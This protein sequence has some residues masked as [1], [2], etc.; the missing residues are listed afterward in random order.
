MKRKIPYK[1]RYFSTDWSSVDLGS[2]SV[3]HAQAH[4]VN[5]YCFCCLPVN[6]LNLLTFHSHRLS[7]PQEEVA[8]TILVTTWYTSFGI[9][10][11]PKPPLIL[12]KF[13]HKGAS[14]TFEVLGTDSVRGQG[15][16]S[17][18]FRSRIQRC[19]SVLTPSKIGKLNY[20][21]RMRVAT[22]GIFM[23]SRDNQFRERIWSYFT[24]TNQ[25]LE[26]L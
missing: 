26:A 20:E 4:P 8:M 24:E 14:A 22:F 16:L 1:R 9:S 12:K 2:M 21:I 3:W 6:L 18:E 5:L 17:W 11:W 15:N 23:L 10:L 13:P 7:L 19:E 25:R